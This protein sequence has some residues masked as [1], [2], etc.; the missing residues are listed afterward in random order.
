MQPAAT[1]ILMLLLSAQALSQTASLAGQLEG[2]VLDPTHAPLPGA[3]LRACHVDTGVEQHVQSDRNGFYRFS[4]LPAGRYE[5]HAA[6][7]GF[8]PHELTPRKQWP[9]WLKPFGR[10][11]R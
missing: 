5:L 8:S 2:S 3:S 9:R 1:A 6:L 7:T 11:R 10:N 4:A